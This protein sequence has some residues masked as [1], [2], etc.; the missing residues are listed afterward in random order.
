MK[1]LS[2]MLIT[3][4][5]C[6]GLLSYK[7]FPQKASY[8]AIINIPIQ[9]NLSQT[10]PSIDSIEITPPLSTND[11]SYDV[12]SNPDRIAYETGFYYEPLTPDVIEF[13]NGK[14]YKSD[15]T[16]PYESLNHVKILYY[17]FNHEIAEGEIICN[18]AIAKDLVEIFYE[19]YLNEY[20]LESVKLVDT[21]DADDELS[22]EANNTSC[23]NYR[24]VPGKKTLSK[25]AQGLAIDVNPFYNPYITY[26][27]G[28]EHITPI[29]SEQYADRTHDFPH[30]ITK[31]D[32]CYQLFISHG[33]SWGGSWKNS[34]DYQHFEKNI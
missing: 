21:F 14:S 20:P 33:F 16:I 32:L 5:L 22:M 31:E 18:S 29:G 25:H 30:K 28:I 23:F 1:K 2:I 19:L 26:S 34:K 13:I 24:S 8:G 12:I 3:S 27:S 10:I 9:S 4:L 7:A 17:N 11:I 15:C 6:L